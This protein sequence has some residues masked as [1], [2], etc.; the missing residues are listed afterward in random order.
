[1]VL[2][3]F[4]VIIAG[5]FNQF[6]VI[7]VG[8][9]EQNLRLS[10]P[11]SSKNNPSSILAPCLFSNKVIRVTGDMTSVKIARGCSIPTLIRQLDPYQ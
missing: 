9:Y 6:L 3:T 2:L 1:M 7:I 4:L 5:S 10:E 8:Y 11:A